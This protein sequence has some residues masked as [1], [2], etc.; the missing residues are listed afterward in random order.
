M[1]WFAYGAFSVLEED[2]RSSFEDGRAILRGFGY[3]TV[4]DLPML[5]EVK[6]GFIFGY[7]KKSDDVTEERLKFKYRV[8]YGTDV[9]CRDVNIEMLQTNKNVSVKLVYVPCTSSS[10]IRCG[11]VLLELKTKGEK[12]DKFA[13]FQI[14][15]RFF[16]RVADPSLSS[17]F[18][19]YVFRLKS[20]IRSADLLD[21]L[22]FLIFQ[23]E[24]FEKSYD[25]F[26]HSRFLD[27]F[28]HFLRTDDVLFD[29][30]DDDESD[31]F[32]TGDPFNIHDPYCNLPFLRNSGKSEKIELPDSIRVVLP[33]KILL[34]PHPV[35]CQ[36]SSWNVKQ[37]I[38]SLIHHFDVRRFC[39]VDEY[40]PFD[41]EALAREAWTHCYEEDEGEHAPLIFLRYN[42]LDGGTY[43]GLTRLLAMKDDAVTYM[44]TGS[45]EDLDKVYNFLTTRTKK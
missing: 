40:S 10:K 20:D 25:E 45:D 22:Y 15:T 29:K 19:D 32:A 13:A 2:K 42:I 35:L 26:A 5:R 44:Y 36:D 8:L 43:E 11:D 18:K 4:K 37:I 24:T 9:M 3:S 7:V 39:H 31:D 41:F 12:V 30:D 6:N 16:G 34:G 38:Y 28:V 21:A 27:N 1:L 33:R 23:K 14:S 17:K